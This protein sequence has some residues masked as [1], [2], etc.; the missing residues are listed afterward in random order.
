VSGL[1]DEQSCAF[2]AEKGHWRGSA[3]RAPS[4]VDFR[5]TYV[6]SFGAEKLRPLAVEQ[7]CIE[8][9]AR[10]YYTPGLPFVHSAA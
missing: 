4:K 10:D 3:I 7:L 9:Y 6:H 8:S 1:E 2:I 5:V